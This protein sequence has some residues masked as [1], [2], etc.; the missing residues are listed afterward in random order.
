MRYF[1]S[2]MLARRFTQRA[3]VGHTYAVSVSAESP[4]RAQVG[5]CDI[6]LSTEALPGRRHRKGGA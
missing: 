2:R 1:A 6:G 4:L 5:P 3:R